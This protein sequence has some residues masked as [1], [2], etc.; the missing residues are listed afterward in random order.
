MKTTARLATLVVTAALLVTSIPAM[1]GAYTYA[2]TEEAT[3]TA[4]D[5][6][7]SAD[8]S[9]ETVDDEA[10]FEVI[11]GE[12]NDDIV[13][14]E[15]PAATNPDEE[16]PG[17]TP[18]EP[19]ELTGAQVKEIT[20]TGVSASSYSYTKI[21]VSWNKIDGV[22]GYKVYRA[23]KKS[24]KYSLVK[25]TSNTSY[26]NTGRT[27]GK[28][29]YYKVR[30]YK[31]IGKYTYYT[32]YSAVKS[33]KAKLSTPA[34]TKIYLPKDN[35]D[36]SWILDPMNSIQDDPNVRVV[37][38]KVSGAT[39]YQVYRKRTD[40]STWKLMKTVSSKYNYATDPMR[41]KYY[42]KYA[43]IKMY[44]FSDVNYDWEY[45]VRAIKKKGKTT[46]YGSFSK[47]AKYI[48]TWTFKQLQE[49]LAAYGESL[50]FPMYELQDENGNYDPDGDHIAP[51]KNGE[52]YHLEHSLRPTATE[53]DGSWS[54][55][56]PIRVYKYHNK[57]KLLKEL[58]AVVKSELR[59]IA[60]SNPQ[61]WDEFYELDESGENWV[62]NYNGSWS[63]G[64]YFKP[65]KKNHVYDL[66]LL[67]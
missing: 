56:F 60:D 45:K 43:G 12:E 48:P 34:I 8:E 44:D 42:G 63:F 67:Y 58:Q 13:T 40:K 23:A 61:Y 11:D 50:E 19:K 25:T 54:T 16:E 35:G 20:P 62:G 55:A 2:D 31:K 15:P 30:G 52:T 28:T 39:G 36:E 14:P 64:L 66:Y 49:E 65:I 24:G 41:G 32:K 17:Q 6:A 4:A 46:T 26:I 29:Y 22:D 1:Q 27:T 5:I 21:K 18:T 9:V 38:K 51:K 59:I 7:A 53:N 10:V 33:A 3:N 37:W 47:A 57:E